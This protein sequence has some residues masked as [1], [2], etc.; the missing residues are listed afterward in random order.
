MFKD[1]IKEQ[2]GVQLYP[3]VSLLMFVVF[4]VALSLRAMMYKKPE[5]EEM[6][7]IPLD[8]ETADSNI[9]ENL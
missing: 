4:F 9:Y 2:A 5:L 6:S 8:N 7:N 3:I 1:F